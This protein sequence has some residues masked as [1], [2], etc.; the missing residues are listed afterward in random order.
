MTAIVTTLSNGVRVCNFSSPHSFTF[1]DG[2]EL[3]AVPTSV[4]EQLSLE[5]QEEAVQWPGLPGV[6][7]VRP[8]FGLT[9]AVMQR[10]SELNDSEHVDVV[11]VPFPVLDAMRQ[12]GVLDKFP[13]AATCLLADR[14]EKICHIDRFCR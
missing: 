5:R 14:V 9:D 7:A 11:I 10:L 8:V 1:T 6:M 13:K 3:P 12:L 2:S 4:C